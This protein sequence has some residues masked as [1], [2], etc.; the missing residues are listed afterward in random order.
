MTT[1]CLIHEKS[2]YLLQHAHNPVQWYAWSDEAFE[3]AEA[4]NKPIFLSIGYATCHWCHV[5]EKETFENEEAAKFLN[6]TFVCIKVDREERPDIDAVYMA[7]CQMLTGSGGWPL[8]I[9]MTPDKKPFFAGTYIPKHA[10]LNQ[11]GIVELS[12][13]V[14]SIWHAQN[15]KVV[16]SAVNIAS[17][18]SKA[19]LFSSSEDPDVSLLNQ[20][21]SQLES[22]F[23]ERFGGFERAPKFPTPHRLLFLLRCFHRTG[24]SHAL[25]MVCKTLTSMRL[26]GIWDHIGF[27]FH[28]YSTDPEWLLP[29]FEKM[30]YDQALIALTYLEAY[31][32]NKEPLYAQTANEIFTYVLRDM[33]SEQGAFFAAEDA[34]SEGEEGKFYIWTSEDFKQVLGAE[35]AELWQRI[36]NLQTEGNFYDEASSRKTGTNILHLKRLPAQLA[37]ETGLTEDEWALQLNEIRKKLFIVREQRIH[38]LKDD[39]V[40]MDW[41]GLM[42]AALA[43]G[44]RVLQNPKYTE[45]AQKATQ[46]LLTK[47]RKG[48]SKLFHRYREGEVAIHAQA[49][50]YAFFILGLLELYQTTFEP[51]YLEDAIKLQQQMINDFWDTASGGFYSTPNEDHELPVRPKELYDGAIPSANS[52]ALFNLLCLAKMTGD[53]NWQ[54][55]AHAHIRAFAGTVI[56]QPTA[57]TFFLLGLDFALNPGQEVV[58]TGEPEAKDTKELLAALNFNF[59][60]NKVMLVKSD[61]YAKQL[62]NMAG[63]T[64]GLQVV[65]GKAT[66]HICRGHSCTDPTTDVETM[67]KKILSNK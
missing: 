24:N 30:L 23:N 25:E 16:S 6:D 62:A 29:H 50:D 13:Q 9:F 60:P 5:M 44:G 28:R 42:I 63:Y 66:A 15:N 47:M 20:A 38:P 7:A 41:N 53:P 26:G 27:G 17:A 39:K 64:D 43:R 14:K 46:F 52:V 8:T 1:N 61:R 4:E 40:L 21:Y 56:A 33:T 22:S 11:P 67:L 34:D 12:Q 54:E 37:E 18:L 35:D 48:E 19:F 59:L 3:K 49:N 65:Q 32:I 2:P 57:F 10:R 45:A 36:F 58:I 31:Q 55:R 51:A